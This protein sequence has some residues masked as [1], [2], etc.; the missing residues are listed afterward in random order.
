MFSVSVMLTKYLLKIFATLCFSDNECFFSINVRVWSYWE[1]L[2]KR[3][4]KA[5]KSFFF[6]F[7]VSKDTTYEE[8][9]LASLFRFRCFLYALRSSSFPLLFA[10][11]SSLDLIMICFLIRD[12]M[13]GLLFPRTNRFLKRC[14][15][16]KLFITKVFRDPISPD[17]IM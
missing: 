12:V 8:V 15:V 11:F 6:H 4:C 5:S 17:W 9:F 3:V 14:T 16:F 1:S 7:I 2:Q 10:F 13:R